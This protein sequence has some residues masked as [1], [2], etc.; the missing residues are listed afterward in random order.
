MTRGFQ[1]AERLAQ[2]LKPGEHGGHNEEDRGASGGVQEVW[3]RGLRRTVEEDPEICD[4]RMA[5]DEEGT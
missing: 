1:F 5:C 2:R 4:G 3:L